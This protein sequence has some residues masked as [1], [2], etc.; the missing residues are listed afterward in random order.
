MRDRGA[1]YLGLAVFLAL[2]TFPMWYNPARGVTSRPPDL[3]LPANARQ[4]VMPLDYMRGSHM[5]LLVN[6]RESVVRQGV[7][8]FHAPDGKSYEMSL[9]KTCLEACHGDKTQFCDRCHTYAGVQGPYCWECH[10]NSRVLRA[11]K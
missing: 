8:T 11:G 1:I 4:C 9:T 6:W 2:V 10:N 7:R 5:Q 3:K